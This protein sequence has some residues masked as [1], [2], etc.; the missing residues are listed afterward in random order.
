[1]NFTVNRKTSVF[2]QI[3]FWILYF[4]LA[5]NLIE[6]NNRGNFYT[7]MQ[8]SCMVFTFMGI[9]YVNALILIPKLF[10][11]KR[12]I[13]YSFSIL[14]IIVI[15]PFVLLAAMKIIHSFFEPFENTIRLVNNSGQHRFV[16]ILIP[17]II[18]LFGSTTIRLILDFSRNERQR[19]QIEKERLLAETKYLRSQMNPHFFLNALNNLNAI[20]RLSPQKSEKYINTLADMMRYVTYDCKNNRVPIGKEINYIRNYIYAQE[21]KDDDISVTFNTNIEREETQIEPM[22]L[23]PFVENAFKHGVFDDGEQHPILISID[24]RKGKIYFSCKNKANPGIK[25][26][27]DP[28]YSGVGIK[29]VKERL[30]AGYRDK[31]DL[32]IDNEGAYFVVELVLGE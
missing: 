15:T 24:Q 31:Y 5:Y 21:I 30:E 16:R 26:N 6:I 17:T 23:M 9:S 18:F 13:L 27:A 12:Y 32:R 25:T 11:R 29:N 4:M 10:T 22:L 1:M 20:I 19:I 8:T 7:L 14:C 2:I 3:I 28:S